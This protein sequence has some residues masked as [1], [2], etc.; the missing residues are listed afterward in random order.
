MTWI[1]PDSP[2]TFL[3]PL[4]VIFEAPLKIP[5]LNDNYSENRHFFHPKE[6]GK[7]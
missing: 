1:K 6:T 3:P 7:D 2:F 4:E 5:K